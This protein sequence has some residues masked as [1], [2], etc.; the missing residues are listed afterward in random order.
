MGMCTPDCRK[1]E[2][3]RTKDAEILSRRVYG[4]TRDG[5]IN[6]IPS[7]DF[8]I[9]NSRTKNGSKE[10]L[11]DSCRDRLLPTAWKSYVGRH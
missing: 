8:Y 2:E 5:S 9:L 1:K 3:K 6:L 7:R 4:E 11:I 10:L